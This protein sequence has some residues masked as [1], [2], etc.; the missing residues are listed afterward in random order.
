MSEFMTMLVIGGETYE[1]NHIHPNVLS[2]CVRLDL[3]FGIPNV[4]IPYSSDIIPFVPRFNRYLSLYLRDAST[5]SPS[6]CNMALVEYF[7]QT[8]LFLGNLDL[9]IKFT[10]DNRLGLLKREDAMIN[11]NDTLA[12]MSDITSDMK[13][14]DPRYPLVF[15]KQNKDMLGTVKDTP[16][17]IAIQRLIKCPS[18]VCVRESFFQDVFKMYPNTICVAGGSLHM[19]YKEDTGCTKRD[20]D[21]FIYGVEDEKEIT[22]MVEN[23]WK[24]YCSKFSTRSFLI[25]TPCSVTMRSFEDLNHP[26]IMQIVLRRYDSLSSMLNSFDLD[27]SCIAFQGKRVITNARGARYIATN[28]NVIDIDRQSTTLVHRLMKYY[29][30]ESVNIALPGYDPDRIRVGRIFSKCKANNDLLHLIS[31]KFKNPHTSY[32]TYGHHNWIS[33]SCSLATFISRIASVYSKRKRIPFIVRYNA[34]RV[35]TIA[36]LERLVCD[37][38]VCVHRVEVR[39]AVQ[40]SFFPLNSNFYIRAYLPDYKQYNHSPPVPEQGGANGPI[41]ALV[42]NHVTVVPIGSKLVM[43]VAAHS[44]D[45]VN[46]DTL[47]ITHPEIWTMVRSVLE[48]NTE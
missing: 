25:R 41:H 30:R 16:D 28:S 31:R 44:Q 15:P 3:L 12:Y 45:I 9:A 40:K 13:A 32:T 14:E 21:W 17:Y 38:S 4:N 33:T 11:A 2:E 42:G 7:R 29:Y 1:R 43:V 10:F 46:I 6:C 22:H 39:E 18:R 35:F 27:S 24:L 26:N 37:P 36:A 48:G 20:T 47:N 19:C 5:P 8:L 23:I 34:S